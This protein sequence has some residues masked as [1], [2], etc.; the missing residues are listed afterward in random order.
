[1]DLGPTNHNEDGLLGPDSVIVVYMD[2]LGK[3]VI[4]GVT[5]WPQ[6]H[7]RIT[8]FASL[9]QEFALTPQH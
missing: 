6:P 4:G 1:M 3:L 8:V 5:A 9:I 7:S 2:P